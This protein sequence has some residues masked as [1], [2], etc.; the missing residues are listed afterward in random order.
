MK[1][2]KLL[3]PARR[4]AAVEEVQ[5][6]LPEVSERRACRVLGQPRAVQRYTARVRDDEAP[7]TGRIV[8]LASVDGRYG[9]PRITGLLRNEGWNANYKRVERIWRQAGLKVP[10]KQPRRGR[11]W[12]NDGSC[13]RLR[14]D[15]KDHVWAYDFVAARTHDGQPLR[16]LVVM[17]EWTRECLSIDVAR[18]LGSDDV[19][20]RLSWL[21]AT[22]GV[23]DHVRSPN[24]SE[25]T[26]KAVRAWLGKVGVKTLSIAAQPLGERLRG[27]P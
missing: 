18:Q 10:R 4:R 1:L 15:R 23:P 16:L 14:P 11:L 2:G 24:G 3:S 27:K 21:M 17:N 5:R 7:L 12:L 6:A 13:I 22:C 26:A 8:E 20:E 19:L 25:F 9:S